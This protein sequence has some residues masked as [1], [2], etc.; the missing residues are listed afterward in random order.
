[1]RS[2]PKSKNYIRKR[3]SSRPGIDT[4]RG[5][6]G[7]SELLCSMQ[8]VNGLPYSMQTGTYTR[9]CSK[10]CLRSQTI[11]SSWLD[12]KEFTRLLLEGKSFRFY[13]GCLYGFSF[14]SMSKRKPGSKSLKGKRCRNGKRTDS[15]SMSKSLRKRY[16]EVLRSSKC[17]SNAKSRRKNHGVLCGKLSKKA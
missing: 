2:Y 14:R 11:S 6:G 4:A 13:P 15:F 10:G 8:P 1:M 16:R 17:Q 3:R 5:K 9:G 12:A 7:R